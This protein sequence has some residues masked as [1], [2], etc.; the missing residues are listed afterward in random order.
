MKISAIKKLSIAALIVGMLV[1]VEAAEVKAKIILEGIETPCMLMWKPA[2]K[3]YVVKQGNMTREVS[4]ESI[5]AMVVA[6]PAGWDEIMKRVRSANPATAIPQLQKVMQDYVMLEYDGK[7]GAIAAQIYLKQGKAQEALKI[8]EKVVQ[9]NKRA[10]YASDMSPFYWEALIAT[11]KTASLPNMLNRAISS[12]NRTISAAALIAR[13]DLLRSE[14][15]NMEAL[16]D[17]YLRVVYLYN[18][19]TSKQPEAIYKAFE[20]FNKLGQTTYAEKMRSLM[21]KNSTYK[22][23]EWAKKMTSGK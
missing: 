5:Q 18:S 7:A 6:P 17:G 9:T 1:S 15:K 4:P 16:K 20:T 8:C 3:V 12:G 22:K 11:G 10:A 21:L 14:D 13:G 23:S 2:S 19:E